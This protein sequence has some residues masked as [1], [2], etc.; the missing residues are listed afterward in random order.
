VAKEPR[1]DVLAAALDAPET[2]EGEDA[3]LSTDLAV[4]LAIELAVRLRAKEPRPA[5][6]V[7][8]TVFNTVRG[9]DTVFIDDAPWQSEKAMI[10]LHPRISAEDG[11]LLGCSSLREEM[12]RLRGG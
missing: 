4:A 10:T 7:V 5:K 12:T 2:E 8:P 11:R 6:I 9:V 3:P 1:A